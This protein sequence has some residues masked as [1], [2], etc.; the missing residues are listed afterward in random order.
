MKNYAD[1][2]EE[3]EN[4]PPQRE[5]EFRIDL[6][7]NARPVVHP[8]RRM[9]PKEKEELSSQTRE[10][11]WKG[12]IRPSFSAWGAAVVFVPKS[13]GTLRLCVDYRDLNKQTLKNKYP[14]PRIDDL[15]DQLNGATVFS[16]MDLATGFHQLRIAEDCVPLTVFR[17]PDLFYEWLVMLFGLC[18]APAYF[19]DLMNRVFHGVLNKFVLVFIDDIL[20]YSKS[21]GEHAKHLEQ[22]LKILRRN[23]LKAKFSKCVFWQ[24]EVKFLGHVVSKE[25]IA[26]DPSKITAIQNWKQPTTPTEVRSFLGLASYYQKFVKDFSKISGVLT[27]LTKKHEKFKWTPE[28]EEAF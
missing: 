6:I 3:V 22:V 28:C 19:V 21:E 7:P 1:V 8:I 16:R 10:L 23:V 2:F 9:A 27:K 14:L 12:L 25:G 26:V 13:D 20:I 4:L 24:N 11:L 5:I 18:N 15:L 17:G